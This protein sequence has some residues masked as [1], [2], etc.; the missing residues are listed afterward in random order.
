VLPPYY[1]LFF[2]LAV[3]LP[4][5]PLPCLA[6]SFLH[7]LSPPSL[8]EES[9]GQRVQKTLQ[10]SKLQGSK[11]GSERMKRREEGG[12]RVHKKER[13]RG[14]ARAKKRRGKGGSECSK[15]EREGGQRVQK[16]RRQGATSAGKQGGKE[17]SE[18]RKRREGG[19]QRVQKRRGGWGQRL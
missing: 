13:A 17:G 19:M 8:Y 18:C 3:P 2:A 7:P 9:R 5:V 12:Q 1:F 6:L 15:T 14:A 4:S 16:K 10:K 11:G